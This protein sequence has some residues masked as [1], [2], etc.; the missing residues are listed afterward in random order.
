MRILVAVLLLT[1]AAGPIM[2]QSAPAPQPAPSP[3]ASP[4]APAANPAAGPGGPDI[5]MPQVILQV[6]D[7]SVENVDA[8]LPPEEEM[9]PP[10]RTI[11][12]LSEG[13]MAVGEPAIPAAAVDTEGPSRPAN[14]G[15][16]PR[17]C[18]SGPARRT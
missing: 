1:C 16:F 15:C 7:V 13:E 4:R 18:F 5:V 3:Q 9:L 14:T 11:P 8:Q 2:A 12:A 10:V 17:M 6:Q